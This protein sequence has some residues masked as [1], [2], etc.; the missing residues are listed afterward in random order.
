MLDK[1]DK[2]IDDIL[3]TNLDSYDDVRNRY[4]RRMN[5]VCY[6]LGILIGMLFM[7]ALIY[8]NNTKNGINPDN[9][10]KI[11]IINEETPI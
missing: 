11:E 3:K 9:F 7:L 6:L 2:E 5:I 1:L 8:N 4:M 10:K